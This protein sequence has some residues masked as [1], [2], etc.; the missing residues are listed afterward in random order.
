M[1]ENPSFSPPLRHLQRLVMAAVNT[2]LPPRCLGSGKVVDAPG[3]LDAGFWGEL[4][5]VSAPACDC[6]GLP[7]SF[8]VAEGSLCA[9]CIDT[10]PA[11]D[12]ARAAVIYNDASRQLVLDFKYGDKLH[13]VA[14]FLP[15]L[16]RAGAEM[17][18][19][20]DILIPVPLH[21]RRLW[22]RRFNQSALLARAIA[23]D[24]D[25]PCLPDALQRNRHTV[26]QKGLSRSERHLNVRGAF[27]VRPRG[28]DQI[29][30]K[31]VMIVD[32]VF[33]SGA[34]LNECARILKKA[35]AAQVFVLTLARVTRE[36]F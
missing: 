34:T 13:A 25:L 15:W 26:P 19:D 28:T 11:F 23:R 21:R 12:K 29:K 4:A 8:A 24:T 22:Q 16:R 1:S 36:E 18:A 32:D 5:F 20:T 31:R 10:P 30:G 35:G 2:L 6:C 9:A 27:A 3:M 14:T 17:L 7:F 33:T